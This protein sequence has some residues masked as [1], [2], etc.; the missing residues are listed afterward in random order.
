MLYNESSNF[1]ENHKVSIITAIRN[2]EVGIQNFISKINQISREI[3][4]CEIQLI[5]VEDGSSDKTILKVLEA[6]D[7]DR[8]KLFQ[9]KNGCGQGW[10]IGIG[11]LEIG[12]SDFVITMDSDLSHNPECIEIIVLGLLKGSTL[13]QGCK[14]LNHELKIRDTLSYYFGLISEKILGVPFTRQNTIY[15]GISVERMNQIQE[16]RPSFWEFLRFT[17]KEWSE[18]SVEFFRFE[19]NLRQSGESKF[20]LPRLIKFALVGLLTTVNFSK[21]LSIFLLSGFALIIC[22]PKTAP[23]VIIYFILFSFYILKKR[24][25]DRR[26]NLEYKLIFAGPSSF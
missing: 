24:R 6:P 8:V 17:E 10:A 25:H 22:F 15:R 14:S 13:V 3:A 26:I 4:D 16:K 23:V 19:S 2:E 11:Y 12:N 5:L 18:L 9:I 21:L 1:T 20:N 7:T